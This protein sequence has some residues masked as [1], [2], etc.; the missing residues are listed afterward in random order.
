M[1][2][3]AIKYTSCCDMKCLLGECKVRDGGGC[4]HKCNLQGEIKKLQYIID[5]SG[6]Y[7]NGGLMVSSPDKIENYYQNMTL[8]ERK[9]HD[10]LKEDAPS[11][12]KELLEELGEQ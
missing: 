4:V 3:D 1:T 12:I 5:G 10:E 7:C 8:E 11:I 6:L 9:E 2:E